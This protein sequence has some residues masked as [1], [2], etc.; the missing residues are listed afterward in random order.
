MSNLQILLAVGVTFSEIQILL[1]QKKK[2]SKSV[3]VL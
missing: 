2:N 3:S 1:G